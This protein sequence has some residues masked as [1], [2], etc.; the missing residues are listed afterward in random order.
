MAEYFLMSSIRLGSSSDIW[1]TA[2]GIEKGEW[3]ISLVQEI[4]QYSGYCKKQYIIQLMCLCVFG[5]IFKTMHLTSLPNTQPTLKVIISHSLLEED[6]TL[7]SRSLQIFFFEFCALGSRWGSALTRRSAISASFAICDSTRTGVSWS[8]EEW[9]EVSE[10]C[11]TRGLCPGL[12]LGQGLE[13]D[14]T[15]GGEEGGTLEETEGLEMELTREGAEGRKGG[16]ER[17]RKFPGRPGET[18]GVWN[19]PVERERWLHIFIH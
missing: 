9:E 14:S 6:R 13:V 19:M 3:F 8:G 4:Q 17:A 15:G 2:W 5:L 10:V 11:P 1:N 12:R 7:T 18:R 16:R